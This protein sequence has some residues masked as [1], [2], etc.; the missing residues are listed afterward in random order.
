MKKTLLFIILTFFLSGTVAFA[1][2]AGNPVSLIK[3][4][5][6]GVGFRLSDIFTQNFE[7]Y[8]LKRKYSDG[9]RIS[10][11]KRADFENDKYFMMTFTY[12]IMDQLN[13]F[14]TLGVVD[15]GKII[16]RQTDNDWQGELESN[17]VWALGAKGKIFEFDNG[18]G[19]SL[20]AWYT[21]YDNRSV[22]NWKSKETGRTAEDLGWST[23]DELDYWQVDAIA[24]AYWKI[25]AFTPYV[26]LGYT[27]CD[28]NYDGRWTQNTDT[29]FEHWVSYDGSFTNDDNL[30]VL[31]GL[32]VELGA[33]FKTNIQGTFVSSTAITAGI[34]YSF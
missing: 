21:R 34:S 16:D 22:T 2:Q 7:H 4:G 17:F 25:K 10:S 1:Q 33:H 28:V 12:G 31:I 30:T 5:E 26:G 18:L 14:A 29:F 19:F 13:L 27:Y 20:A 11:R 9:T 24:S 23:D 8:D 32:D 6:I 3:Q 15:G